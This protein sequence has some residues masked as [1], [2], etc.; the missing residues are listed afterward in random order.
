MEDVP[1]LTA[2]LNLDSASVQ[3]L[4]RLLEQSRSD[5]D[6]ET[7]PGVHEAVDAV[8]A[9]LTSA[10][11]QQDEGELEARGQLAAEAK[12]STTE[13]SARA[14]ADTSASAIAELSA[15][16]AAATERVTRL[17]QTVTGQVVEAVAAQAEALRPVMRGGEMTLSTPGKADRRRSMDVDAVPPSA[18]LQIHEDLTVAVDKLPALRARL[19]EV[20]RRMGN[21]LRA[22]EEQRAAGGPGGKGSGAPTPLR[23]RY[24]PMKRS[25]AFAGSESDSVVGIIARASCM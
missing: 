4:V 24:T 14:S 5:V 2:S 19:E 6:V 22:I 18:A 8:I 15:Q 20:T 13:V 21:V 16:V 1:A 23:E 11:A 10:R 9:V 25:A 3:L 7:H 12:P 17:R